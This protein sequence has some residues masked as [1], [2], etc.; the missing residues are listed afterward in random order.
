[1]LSLGQHDRSFASPR[2]GQAPE[3]GVRGIHLLIEQHLGADDLR[4][5]PSADQLDAQTVAGH[6][7]LAAAVR[8][9]LRR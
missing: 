1:L 3:D 2:L 8:G 4:L 9:T 5:Q 7:S 6:L